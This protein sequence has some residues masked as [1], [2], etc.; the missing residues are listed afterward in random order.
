MELIEIKTL[1]D[2]TNTGV[3][4]LSQGT[5]LQIDQHK[6]WITLKQ[7]TEIRSVIDYEHSPIPELVDI[8]GLGFGKSYK[9]KHLVWTWRFRPDRDMI[10]LVDADAIGG[11][12]VDID[13]VPII[14][15]LNETINIAKQVFDVVDSN[16]KNT[17][18]T[19]ITK[20]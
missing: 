13:Q 5:Q 15:N 11:L 2:V 19:L 10:Y 7:C 14:K 9:G 6:N 8:S 3:N 4:R 12:L 16:L 1:I 18:I 17:V 20:I